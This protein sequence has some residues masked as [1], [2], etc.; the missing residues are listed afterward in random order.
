MSFSGEERDGE[1]EEGGG[2]VERTGQEEGREG[3]VVGEARCRRERYKR[4]TSLQV[5][6]YIKYTDT[7]NTTW[8]MGSR[9]IKSFYSGP[10]SNYLVCQFSSDF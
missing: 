9:T 1:G 6:A 2:E 3:G 7:V 8:T 10:T 4:Q 5:Y